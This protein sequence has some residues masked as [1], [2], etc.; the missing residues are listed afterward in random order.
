MSIG[1]WPYLRTNRDGQNVFRRNREAQKRTAA[2][3]LLP[4]ECLLSGPRF[5]VLYVRMGRRKE[6][7]RFET[8]T[9]VG[10]FSSTALRW[11][12]WGNYQIKNEWTYFVFELIP[13]RSTERLIKI[14]MPMPIYLAQALT[15]IVNFGSVMTGTNRLTSCLI[16]QRVVWMLLPWMTIGISSQGFNQLYWY[17]TVF[18]R[19][20][21]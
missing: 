3:S 12:N 17:G 19:R 21:L 5:S 13:M 8:H 2:P 9:L 11:G 14:Y 7:H 20:A 16:S 6:R 10:A 18:R 15:A 4:N 1:N